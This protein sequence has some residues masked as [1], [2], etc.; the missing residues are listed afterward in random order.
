DSITHSIGRAQSEFP[1]RVV[2]HIDGAGLGIGELC[3]LGDDGSQDRLKIERRVHRLADLAERP[4]LTYG[5]T[6]FARARLHFVKQAEK[7]AAWR[8]RE[9]ARGQPRPR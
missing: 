2:E 9:Q 4:Q 3:R 5:L 8:R 6:E 1:A 7:F